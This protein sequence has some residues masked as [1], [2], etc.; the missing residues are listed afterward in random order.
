[1]AQ[2][3]G[4]RIVELSF[5]GQPV[6]PEQELEIVVNQYRGV[7]G[8]NYSMFDKSKIVSEITVD[9]TE[10]IGEYLEKHPVIEATSNQNFKVLQ[11]LKD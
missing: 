9:M 8:G 1:M 3:E 5:E 10:L 11:A 2:S 6:E 4:S 7:G